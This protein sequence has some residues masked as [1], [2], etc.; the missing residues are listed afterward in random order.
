MAD[1]QDNQLWN[2]FEIEKKE[3]QKPNEFLQRGMVNFIVW[4]FLNVIAAM[5][6]GNQIIPVIDNPNQ[7]GNGLDANKSFVW[8]RNLNPKFCLDNTRQHGKHQWNEK[9]H[10]NKF[11]T[12]SKIEKKEFM[13][14]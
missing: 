13:K 1:L 7:I 3:F 14:R 6:D 8:M 10:G 2:P 4:K 11:R 12:S 9:W 5:D